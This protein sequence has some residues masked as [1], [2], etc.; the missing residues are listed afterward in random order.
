MI[1]LPAAVLLGQWLAEKLQQELLVE[2]TRQERLVLLK[3]SNAV[4]WPQ[5]SDVVLE[6]KVELQEPEGMGEDADNAL[7]ALTKSGTLILDQ[8]AEADRWEVQVAA[9]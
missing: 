3:L 2:A 5:A 7:D 9:M 8:G 1:R 4:G 6:L